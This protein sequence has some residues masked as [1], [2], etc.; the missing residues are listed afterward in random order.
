M[1]MY[2]FTETETILQRFS[3]PAAESEG[4]TLVSRLMFFPVQWIFLL[5]YIQKQDCRKVK[6][7]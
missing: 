5:K 2:G 4:K 7:S 6:D 3:K 1:F